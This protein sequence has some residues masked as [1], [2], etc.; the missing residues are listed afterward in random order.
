MCRPSKVMK[1]AHFK[2]IKWTKTFVTGPLDPLHDKYR[3]YCQICKTNV[4]HYSKGAR[5]ILRHYQKESHPRK[6]QRWRYEHLGTIDKT[7][8]EVLHDFR[9]KDGH[10]LTPLELAKELPL[11]INAPLV[12]IGDK[13]P[14]YD[15]FLANQ[16]ALGNP[17]EH[18]QAAQISLICTF[19]PSDGNL[20]LL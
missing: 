3:F 17:E 4:C 19:V 1:D 12:D 14:F 10:R 6:D 11:F 5:E 16:Y 15:Y 8:G 7:T 18:T 20:S 13:L 9:G 2:G